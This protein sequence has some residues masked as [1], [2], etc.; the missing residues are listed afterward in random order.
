MRLTW[1]R[2]DAGLSFPCGG[3]PVFKSATSHP[4]R[5]PESSTSARRRSNR[6]ISWPS[7]VTNSPSTAMTSDCIFFHRAIVTR[8]WANPCTPTCSSNMLI[9]PFCCFFARCTYLPSNSDGAV[10]RE[11]SVSPPPN[12]FEVKHQLHQEA[13]S[14]QRAV[15]R[16]IQLATNP[17]SRHVR[18]YPMTLPFRLSEA[19][20]VGLTNTYGDRSRIDSTPVALCRTRND[21]L[22]IE[23]DRFLS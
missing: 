17:Q 16:L 1:R 3:L 8:S 15:Y 14:I 18:R 9:A 2:R 13:N 20:L 22:P 5:L 23:N 4:R 19:A 6:P 10:C 7:L 11:K 21:Q 12:A